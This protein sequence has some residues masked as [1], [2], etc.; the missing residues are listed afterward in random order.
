MSLPRRTDAA[1]TLLGAQAFGCAGVAGRVGQGVR[2]RAA[3]RV[4]YWLAWV[5]CLAPVLGQMHRVYH[6]ADGP[7]RSE[8]ARAALVWMHPSANAVDEQ[9]QVAGREPSWIDRLF[10]SHRADA[11]CLVFDQ[12][13]QAGPCAQLA[14]VLPTWHALVYQAWWK[15]PARAAFSAAWRWARGPPVLR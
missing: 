1:G 5:L 9:D 13:Q 4:W 3:W 2:R 12:M 14:A 7:S 15:D 6:A 8:S 11:D 10:A